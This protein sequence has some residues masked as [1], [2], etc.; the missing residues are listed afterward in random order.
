MT[1]TSLDDISAVLEAEYIGDE[2]LPCVGNCPLH[3]WPR[4]YD[5]IRKL[6]ILLDVDVM[7]CDGAPE[8]LLE[9]L[10][11][12]H[13]GCRVS[14][15]VTWSAQGSHRFPRAWLVSPLL[16]AINVRYFENLVYPNYDPA[17]RH[18]SPQHP[19]QILQEFVTFAPNIKQVA[20]QPSPLCL[21]RRGFNQA[22]ESLTGETAVRGK[23][24]YMSWSFNAQMT[25]EQF[26]KWQT[27]TD[28]SHLRSWAPWAYPRSE[29]SSGYITFFLPATEA[30]H[31]R[32]I[33]AREWQLQFLVRRGFDV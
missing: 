27:I 29:L 17:F 30:T 21:P 28:L 14:M 3:G 10:S 13:P 18:P 12:Y 15:F 33:S 1:R 2:L 20:M 7:I 9:T 32:P 4:I 25:T 11:Q 31:S 24:E 16:Q 26:K 8:E 23:L 19:N 22:Q 5:L 6:P